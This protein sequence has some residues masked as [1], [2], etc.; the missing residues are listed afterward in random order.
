MNPLLASIESLLFIESK[1]FT[2]KKLATLTQSTEAEVDSALVELKKQQLDR[3]AGVIIVREGNNV[4]LMSAPAQ[5]ELVRAYLA[6]AANDEL[7]R[8]SLETLTIIAYRGPVSKTELELIRG[9]NCSLILRNLM[10]RGLVEEVGTTESGAAIYQVTLDFLRFLGIGSINELPNFEELNRNVH[11]Q[12]LL[13]Q[14]KN[15]QDFFAQ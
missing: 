13:E 15:P 2:L 4:Q 14:K 6:E 9:V 11:L 7:T 5:A 1:P 8:P 12:E 3:N 10:I